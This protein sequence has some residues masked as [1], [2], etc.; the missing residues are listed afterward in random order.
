MTTPAWRQSIRTAVSNQLVAQTCDAEVIPASP[1]LSAGF[2]YFCRV[3]VDQSLA[4]NNAYMGITVAASGAA[5]SY[6][7]VYNPSTGALLSQS[8]DVSS[9]MN[10]AVLLQ[11]PISTLPAQAVNTELWLAVLIGSFSTTPTLV[12]RFSYGTNLGMTSDYRLWMST[13]GSNTY[14]PATAPAMLPATSSQSIPYI[15]IGP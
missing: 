15:S 13:Y 12:G 4:A 11:A 8:A 6:I 5:N 9:Q 3:Y 14:L 1:G 2:I 10:T 7:G